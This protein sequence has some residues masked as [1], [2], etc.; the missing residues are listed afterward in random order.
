MRTNAVCC[1]FRPAPCEPTR[2]DGSAAR[3]RRMRALVVG[4]SGQGRTPRCVGDAV[5]K[6]VE[7]FSQYH[8]PASE[9]RRDRRIAFGAVIASRRSAVSHAA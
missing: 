8:P 9:P 4:E 5:G 1:R 3:K 6:L 7:L 2:R